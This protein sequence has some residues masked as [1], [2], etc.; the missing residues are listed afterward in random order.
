MS[1]LGAVVALVLSACGGN[2]AKTDAAID[3]APGEAGPCGAELFF[4]GEFVDW[5]SNNTNFCG[6]FQAKWQVHGDTARSSSTNPNGRFELCLTPT[7]T[8]RVD[9]TPPTDTSQ[10]RSAPGIYTFPGI[11]IANQAVIAAGGVFSAREISPSEVTA[12]GLTLTAGKAHVL[13]H[14]TGTPRTVTSSAAHGPSLAFDGTTWAPG[15]AG[16]YVF[17][18]NT[19][20]AS[21]T[22]AIGMSGSSVGTGPVPTVADTFTY[23][24]VVA[25]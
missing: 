6:V 2:N 8:T 17:F 9:I 14:V 11:A 16:Q 24:A 21:G 1:K 25:N 18:P 13:V 22:T 23:L 12:A 19:D 15:D 3:V 10:C 20:P 4:T 5:N 7:A